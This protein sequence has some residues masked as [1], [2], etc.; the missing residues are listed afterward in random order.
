MLNS[1]Y[2]VLVYIQRASFKLLSHTTE[3]VSQYKIK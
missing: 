1:H 2:F 3:L